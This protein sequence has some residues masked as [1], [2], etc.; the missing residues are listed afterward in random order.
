MTNHQLW[1]YT[2]GETDRQKDNK[3][4]GTGKYRYIYHTMNK[5]QCNTIMVFICHSSVP[6]RDYPEYLDITRSS[7]SVTNWIE[8]GIQYSLYIG[9]SCESYPMITSTRYVNNR[10]DDKLG[11]TEIG[12]QKLHSADAHKMN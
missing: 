7:E 4:N 12:W 6:N 10:Q 9:F 1:K 5:W 2:G 3:T 11:Q 8:L